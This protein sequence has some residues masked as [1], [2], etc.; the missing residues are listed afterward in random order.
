MTGLLV[1]GLVFGVATLVFFLVRAYRPHDDDAMGELNQRMIE[2]ARAQQELVGKVDSVGMQQ[3]ATTK[4]LT[5]TL[6]ASQKQL[7][8]EMSQ[9]LETAQERMGSNLSESAKSTAKSLGELSQ[10][11]ETIDKAQKNIT[12]L[13]EQVVS[14]QHVL[15]DKH[16]RGAFGEVQLIDLVRDVLP[17][18]AYNFQVVLSNSRRADCVIK[19]PNPPGPIVIDAKFPLTSYAAMMNAE[20]ASE[21]SRHSKQLGTDTKRHIKDIADRYI[22]VGETSDSALMF[23]P[24]EAVY[25]ELHAHHPDVVELSHRLKVFL[26]SPTTMMATLTTVRAVLRDVRMREQAGLIQVEVSTMLKDVE[27]M[28][29]RVRKLESH[30]DLA[31]RDIKDIRI[32]ANKI[33]SRG[34]KIEELELSEAENEPSALASPDPL[35][36]D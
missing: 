31:D 26:V 27:R 23:I 8:S 3:I 34:T 35:P 28:M 22:L 4:S 17:P 9:R 10:R 11:L 20:D 16:A 36:F 18:S 15:D 14:L 2:L 29:D 19:L 30:F 6:N 7:S 5:D 21:R 24:S 33:S 32:S 12:D 1:A 25:A 13:S